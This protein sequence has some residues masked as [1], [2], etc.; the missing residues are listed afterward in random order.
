MKCVKCDGEAT[1][2]R[3]QLFVD[4]FVYALCDKCFNERYG[5]NTTAGERCAQCQQPLNEEFYM[6][7]TNAKFC[8]RDCLIAFCGFKK[9]DSKTDGKTSADGISELRMA[10]D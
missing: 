2:M 1:L 8:S 3:E 7:R 6:S 4:G 9:I 10:Y 5:Y